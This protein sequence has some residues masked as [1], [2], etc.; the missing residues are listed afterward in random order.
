VP[1][2][3]IGKI[4]QELPVVFSTIRFS[5]SDE[6]DQASK[7]ISPARTIRIAPEA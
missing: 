4:V 5:L 7:A 1:A 2:I 6:Q 3:E